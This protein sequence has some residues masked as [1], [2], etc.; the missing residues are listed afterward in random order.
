MHFTS[1]FFAATTYAQNDNRN[2]KRSGRARVNVTSKPMKWNLP[3]LTSLMLHSFMQFVQVFES[4]RL[5]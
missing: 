3:N 5:A 4:L 2:N 1:T